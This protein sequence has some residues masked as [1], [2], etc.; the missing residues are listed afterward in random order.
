MNMADTNLLSYADCDFNQV[1]PSGLV[2]EERTQQLLEIT[3]KDHDYWV[4]LSKA[5]LRSIHLWNY[6]EEV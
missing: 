5:N 3:V 2:A 1:M 6:V 4:I